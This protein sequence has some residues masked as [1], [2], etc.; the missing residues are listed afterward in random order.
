MVE[1]IY[2]KGNVDCM[3]GKEAFNFY[4][5][6]QELNT[7]GNDLAKKLLEE[8]EEKMQKMLG[9]IIK[10]RKE[11]MDCFGRKKESVYFDSKIL[12]DPQEKG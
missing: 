2:V 5:K 4:N 1:E 6:V 12:S 11:V 3:S 9:E 7:E 10:L 8:Y